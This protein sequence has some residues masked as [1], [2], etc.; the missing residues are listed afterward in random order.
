MGINSRN[1]TTSNAIRRSGGKIEEPTKE[2]VSLEKYINLTGVL[3]SPL[4]KQRYFQN[5]FLYK[6]V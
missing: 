2:K 3:I 1:R 6:Y 4:D 5:R